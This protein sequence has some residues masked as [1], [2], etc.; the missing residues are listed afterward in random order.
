MTSPPSSSTPSPGRIR[1][2]A[3]TGGEHCAE[4]RAPPRRS[5]TRCGPCRLRRSP[6]PSG[7]P[8]SSPEKCMSLIEAVPGSRGPAHAPITPWPYSAVCSRSSFTKRA[9]TSAIDVSNSA[10]TSSR[11]VAEQL[12]ELGSVG[13]VALPGVAACRRAARAACRRRT[14]RTRTGLRCRRRRSRSRAC[15]RRCGRGRGTARRTCRRR[16]GTRCR[17]RRRRRRSRGREGASSSITTR[18]EQTDDVRARAHLVA[19]VG[20]RFLERARATELVARFED[21]HRLARARARY[22]AAVRPL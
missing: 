9:V 15:G 19:G 22:A 1:A 20:E 6:T 17:D 14:P 16:T 18:V 10:S 13:R 3:R 5:R 7:T 12:L 2:T 8:S 11:L 4:L 21:E